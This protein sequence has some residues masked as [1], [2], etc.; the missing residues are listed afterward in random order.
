MKT[1]LD[2]AISALRRIANRCVHHGLELTDRWH[3]AER[4]LA[5]SQK[6]AQKVLGK[7]ATRLE[8]ET[9]PKPIYLDQRERDTVLAALRMWQAWEGRGNRV[10]VN[11]LQDTKSFRDIADNGREGPKARLLLGEIDRIAGLLGDA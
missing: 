7:I 5:A 8:R 1:N 3:Q 4:D 2:L 11:D 6:D 10:F 9:D